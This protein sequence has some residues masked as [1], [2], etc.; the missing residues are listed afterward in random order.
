MCGI[1]GVAGRPIAKEPFVRALTELAHRG[2]DDAG[3]YQDSHVSL[4]LRRLAILDLSQS[5]HQPMR[6]EQS[7]AVI[8]YNGEVYNYLELRKELELLGWKFHSSTDTEVVL[9]SVLQWG[10]AALQKFNGMWALAVWFPKEGRLF[11][12]RDRFGVKPFYYILTDEFFAFAS[13]PKAL[14]NLFPQYRH[15]D[16]GA[17][18]DFLAKG[19]LYTGTASFYYGINVLQPGHCGNYQVAT[20][21]IRIWRYWDYPDC[22]PIEVSNDDAD[23]FVELFENAVALRLR[24]DVPL[25]LSLSGG[26]DSTAVLAAT[27]QAANVK[28]TCYTSVY[29]HRERGESKWASRAASK[30][31]IVPIE[32]EA[33]SHRWIETLRTIAWHMDGPGYS[34]AVF[35]LWNIMREARRRGT[36]VVLEGQGADEAFGGYAHYTVANL[37][38]LAMG[39]PR[40]GKDLGEI[41]RAFKGAMKT[42]GR[43]QITFWLLRELIPFLLP[44][45]RR[46]SGAASVLKPEFA[47]IYADSVDN[48]TRASRNMGRLSRALWEDHSRRVL[49]GLLHYGDSISMAHSVENRVPF[50][51]YRIVEWIFARSEK[52]KIAAGETKWILREYLR[53]VG[54]PSIAERSDKQGYL[55]PADS[56]LSAA[57]GRVVRELLLA[58][59]SLILEYADPA[60][61]SHLVDSHIKGRFNVGN[62]LYRLLT[63]EIW[64]QQCIMKR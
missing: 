29:S 20:G 37:L 43:T 58:P 27:Q 12:A 5:G 19:N 31:G 28:M 24:S 9:K 52:L 62:H 6:D 47:S 23:Q 41:A 39:L 40:T 2:P 3:I 7:G 10:E 49:P 33:S 60:K 25:G 13:E 34:P 4:G 53:K 32:V 22:E 8:T 54:Q 15:V 17:L 51:D 36:I 55:T 45:H 16:A 46:R 42:F 21:K 56:W 59:S 64:L 50:M 1:L 14:L 57:N 11:I 18:Y 61:I 35:P 44:L 48:E 26:V 30:Y 63:T 38:D